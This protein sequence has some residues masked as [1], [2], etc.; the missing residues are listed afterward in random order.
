MSDMILVS[1]VMPC[2]NEEAAIGSCIEKIQNTFNN[3]GIDGEIVVC[4]NGSTDSSVEIAESMGVRVVHQSLRGYGNAYLKGFNSARGKYFIMGD[5][6]DTYD[7]RLIPQFLDAIINENYDFVTGSRFLGK[8]GLENNPLLHRLI[9]NPA[10][11]SLLNGLFGTKYTDVYCGFRAFSREVYELIQ[12]I[13]PGMEFNLELAINAGFAKLK[14]KEI[15]I[16]LAPRKG[17]SKLRTLRDGWRSLRMMLLYAPN[18]LFVYPGMFLLTLGM[19]IHIAVLADFLKYEGRSLGVVTG[20]FAT[21]FSVVGFQILSLGLHAKT[22]SWSRRFDRDNFLLRKFY[23]FFNLET[24]L[25][26]GTSMIVGGSSVLL[27]LTLQWLRF[28]LL[29]LPHPEWFTFAAT[30]VIIGFE[31][32]F[33]SLFISAM[34]MKKVERYEVPR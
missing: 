27:Y 33:S 13:S 18:K 19:L 12:P 3:A 23:K 31:I 2:L 7:F 29:P 32:D 28:N 10:I 21:I 25:L 14:I 16:Q 8:K 26:I 30:V 9:G 22:Y 1:V 15:P 5:A 24:G 17:E 11:T 6:D 20:I 34:S 4:D